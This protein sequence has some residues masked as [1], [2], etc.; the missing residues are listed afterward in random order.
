MKNKVDKS[1]FM[2]FVIYVL[3]GLAIG[4][5]LM[6]ILYWE[7]VVPNTLYKSGVRSNIDS[8]IVMILLIQGGCW[9]YIDETEDYAKQKRYYFALPVMMIATK[10][11]MEAGFGLSS[12][13]K[14]WW[15]GISIDGMVYENIS[16]FTIM[17]IPTI[18]IVPRAVAYMIKKEYKHEKLAISIYAAGISLMSILFFGEMKGA[19]ICGFVILGCYEMLSE[20]KGK[21]ITFIPYILVLLFGAFYGVNGKLSTFYVR[22][23]FKR[24]ISHTA[25]SYSFSANQLWYLKEYSSWAGLAMLIVIYILIV[26]LLLVYILK[27]VKNIKRRKIAL[28]LWGVMF[29]MYIIAIVGNMFIDFNLSF[30]A[31]FMGKNSFIWLLFASTIMSYK[32]MDWMEMLQQ[33][34]DI[35]ITS[36]G[37]TFDEKESISDDVFDAERISY[38]G[39]IGDEEAVIYTL[40]NKNGSFSTVLMFEPPID[41]K[42][43]IRAYKLISKY[44]IFDE[45]KC[46]IIDDEAIVF[47]IVYD[48]RIP[49]CFNYSE[50]DFRFCLMLDRAQDLYKDMLKLSDNDCHED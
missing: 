42:E 45:Y 31:P 11:L 39:Y 14:T 18:A 1:F 7:S 2:K 32:K 48:I 41:C 47:S 26:V 16:Y 22:E 27:Y 49:Y 9:L 24:L 37:Y 50:W 20:K 44:D 3:I 4:V 33:D 15:I 19:V 23:T 21:Y 17:L 29:V 13:S 35:C 46:Y 34:I 10:L 8:L 5:G 40:Y 30:S 6:N 43:D 28:F 25:N 12:D 36:E 38:S